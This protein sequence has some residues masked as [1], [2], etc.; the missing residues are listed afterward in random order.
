[1][2]AEVSRRSSGAGGG[3]AIIGPVEFREPPA[4]RGGSGH[5]AT[6]RSLQETSA[7]RNHWEVA[8]SHVY[9]LPAAGSGPLPGGG[10]AAGGAPDQSRRGCSVAARSGMGNQ[11][12]HGPLAGGAQS[13]AGGV[14][15][16]EPGSALCWVGPYQD[17]SRIWA[18]LFL[19]KV[20]RR[21]ARD[22]NHAHDFYT[23][24]VRRRVF[25]L[26]PA[27]PLATRAGRG[28]GH[29][30]G[31]VLRRHCRFCVGQYRSGYAAQPRL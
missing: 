5:G 24:S 3:P 22:G 7:A 9:S 20:R 12:R 23:G 29:D 11:G 2:C 19:P 14:G 27:Q 21:S 26:G 15:P 28:C 10:A 1:M 18:R 8:E 4:I 31:A 6:F 30:R 16:R 25:Q 17:D 13:G